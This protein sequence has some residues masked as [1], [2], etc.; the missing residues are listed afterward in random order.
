MIQL[1]SW[2][3]SDIEHLTVSKKQEFVN[4]KLLKDWNVKELSTSKIAYP[5][6]MGVVSQWMKEAG[7]RYMKHIQC[8]YVDFH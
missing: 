6:S 5:V 7:F 2:A 4:D 3:R 1:K 8:Y